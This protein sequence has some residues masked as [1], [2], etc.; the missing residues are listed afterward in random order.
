VQNVVAPAKANTLED[1]LKAATRITLTANGEQFELETAYWGGFDELFGKKVASFL[2]DQSK[3]M[4][5]MLLEQSNNYT[6]SFYQPGNEKP[7]VV[8]ECKKLMN[9]SLS[10]EEAKAKNELRDNTKSYNMYIGEI[11]EITEAP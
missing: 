9:Q 8:V 1:K 10:G 2:L 11:V 3:K 6:M 7:Y 4:G 5:N